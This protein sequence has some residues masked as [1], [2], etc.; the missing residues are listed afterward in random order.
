MRCMLSPI[1]Y[2]SFP[3][4]RKFLAHN[5]ALTLFLKNRVSLFYQYLSDVFLTKWPWFRMMYAISVI[6]SSFQ[7]KNI[8]NP[9][10]TP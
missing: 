10:H 7:Q 6:L 5:A 8:L 2:A 3:R 1:K 4:M 9:V